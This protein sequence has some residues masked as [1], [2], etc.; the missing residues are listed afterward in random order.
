MGKIKRRKTKMKKTQ[1]IDGIVKIAGAKLKK[2]FF[3]F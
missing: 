3:I 1:K 2:I